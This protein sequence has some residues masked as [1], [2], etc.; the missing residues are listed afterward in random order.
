MDFG[1]HVC[2]FDWE[3]GPAATGA[4]LAA[5][6]RDAEAAGARYLTLMDHFIQAEGFV[7]PTDPILEGYAGLAFAAAHTER[8][9]LGLLVSGVLFRNPGVLAKTVATLDVLSGGRAMLGAGGAW[10]AREHAVLGL[11][12][13]PAGERL[14]RLEEAIEICLRFWSG[15]DG[16]FDGPFHRLTETLGVPRPIAQPHPPVMVGGGGERTTLRIVARYADAW[17]IASFEPDVLRHKL[18]VLRRHCDAEE[19]DPS[20]IA[21][22]ILWMDDPRTDPDAFRRR[23]DDYRDLGFE[24]VFL[25]PFGPDPRRAVAELAALMEA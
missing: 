21:R 12:F 24:T 8:V 1:I 16:P 20:E 6:A 18:D 5:V 19:R 17:N 3:G 13:P 2:T 22:T 4:T 11:D 14:A 10:Y 15:D 25:M 23:L 7:D 9:T